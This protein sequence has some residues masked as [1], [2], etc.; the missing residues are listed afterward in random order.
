LKT[1]LTLT[2]VYAFHVLIVGITLGAIPHYFP[3]LHHLPF[4]A[5]CSLFEGFA[6]LLGLAFLVGMSAFGIYKL[7]DRFEEKLVSENDPPMYG[8]PRSRRRRFIREDPEHSI[9]SY[10]A[11]QEHSPPRRFHL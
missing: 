6:P 8:L 4:G 11:L 5:A 7:L 10:L 3:H 2:L 9:I 1:I